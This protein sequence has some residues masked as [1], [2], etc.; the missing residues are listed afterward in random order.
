ME[1]RGIEYI[2]VFEDTQAWL[3]PSQLVVSNLYHELPPFF[4]FVYMYYF[5]I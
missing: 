1:D 2:A 3:M 4:K 5:I